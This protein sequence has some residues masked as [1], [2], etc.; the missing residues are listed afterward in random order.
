MFLFLNCSSQIIS[1]IF[2]HITP[3]IPSV[4]HSNPVGLRKLHKLGHR[5]CNSVHNGRIIDTDEAML[6]V[7]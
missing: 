2:P 7:N 5:L 1:T 4:I 6:E 3:L